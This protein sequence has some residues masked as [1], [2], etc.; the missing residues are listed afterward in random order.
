M[1][2]A[3]LPCILLTSLFIICLW[4]SHMMSRYSQQLQQQL[5]TVKECLAQQ[6]WEQAKQQLDEYTALWEK[7]QLYLHIITEHEEID[8]AE[9]LLVSLYA[10]IQYEELPES[11]SELAYL[12][13]QLRLLAEMQ[14]LNWGNTF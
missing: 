2:S 7:R 11:M 9:D 13:N 8:Q 4:N 10:F 1:K 3:W 5:Q 14:E 12:N 6:Q